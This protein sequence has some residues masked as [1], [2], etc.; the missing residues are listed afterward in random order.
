MPSR[1]GETQRTRVSLKRVLSR[2]GSA[3]V[4][5]PAADKDV[6]IASPPPS[7]S[8]STSRLHHAFQSIA[9]REKALVV[10]VRGR[11]DE[12]KALKLVQEHTAQ[13]LAGTA[14]P[15]VPPKLALAGV[16]ATFE[17]TQN[18]RYAKPETPIAATYRTREFLADG[19]MSTRKICDCILEAR[20]EAVMQSFIFSEGSPQAQAIMGAILQKENGL[21]TGP[22]PERPFRVVL[23][24]NK[25]SSV[26]ARSIVP[27]SQNFGFSGSRSF[28]DIS[29]S[30]D[31]TSDAPVGLTLRDLS[32]Q[33]DP[34]YVDLQVVSIKHTGRSLDHRKQ[35]AFD[36]GTE[37]AKAVV[38]THNI[39][40]VHSPSR[41][42]AGQSIPSVRDIGYYLAGGSAP[43]ALRNN[44][45][46]TCRELGRLEWSS[47]RD[48]PEQSVDAA[49]RTQRVDYSPVQMPEAAEHTVYVAQ[50]DILPS[51]FDTA[52]VGH[53]SPAYVLLNA[54]LDNAQ[55]S[56]RIMTP[57]L[58]IQEILARL[59]HALVRGVHVKILLTEG[60]NHKESQLGG[61]TN[62]AAAMVLHNFA[63]KYG[64]LDQLQIHWNREPDPE[65]PGHLRAPWG[66]APGAIHAKLYVVD[67]TT[68]AT[69]SYNL[70][71][72][73]FKSAESLI[74]LQEEE[75][76]SA[77]Y[78]DAHHGRGEAYRAHGPMEQ[79]ISRVTKLVARALG[80]RR[81]TGGY[82]AH[83]RSM[84]AIKADVR[85]LTSVRDLAA[86]RATIDQ[87]IAALKLLEPTRRPLLQS[88]LG[89]IRQT[90]P[91]AKLAQI[92]GL[93]VELDKHTVIVD[94]QGDNNDAYAS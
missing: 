77:L 73:S 31:K 92:G 30:I 23:A 3:K 42:P 89:F 33:L 62:E 37:Y 69:G 49:V 83:D 14:P 12:A 80:V 68:V 47:R 65:K 81:P 18:N 7:L 59:Q 35:Y 48:L 54:A 84:E 32:R 60:E 90:L 70:D 50:Q 71:Y 27:K 78:F 63:Q 16:I 67:D 58:Q 64:R 28:M 6:L 2:A 55:Q 39:S 4:G 36:A 86:L 5:L 52:S 45:M 82:D 91:A 24:L 51:Q 40:G 29:G 9:R 72:Q 38:P 76:T 1:V 22:P 20:E 53:H 43:A 85:K 13:A 41:A 15:T 74:F 19:E 57:N 79:K 56:I 25:A 94:R 21:R 8:T 87:Q 66:W 10:N 75:K 11:R 46:Q 44:I 26:F 61:H 93:L 17:N 88:Y 34:R